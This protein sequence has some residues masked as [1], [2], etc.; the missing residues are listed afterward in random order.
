MTQN[1]KYVR[2]IFKI[3]KTNSILIIGGDGQLI[4]IYC[5]FEV[6]V[7]EQLQDLNIGDV[8]WVEAVKMTLTLKDVYIIKGKAY[9]VW[10][11]QVLSKS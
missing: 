6:E 9:Y 8:V 3:V 10:Y 7:I 2:E 5:P 4:R 11:F 1:E